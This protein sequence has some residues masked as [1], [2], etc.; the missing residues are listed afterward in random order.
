MS[1]CSGGSDS[2]NAEDTLQTAEF[3]H[4]LP[5]TYIKALRVAGFCETKT[6]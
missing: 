3:E 6:Q 5:D 4:V 1:E 2:D